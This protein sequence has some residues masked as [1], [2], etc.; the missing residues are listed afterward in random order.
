MGMAEKELITS[1]LR[2]LELKGTDTFLRKAMIQ[3]II[4][5]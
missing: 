5:F 2:V 1:F 4:I 3:I